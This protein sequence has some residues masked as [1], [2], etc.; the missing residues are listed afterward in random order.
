MRK[1]HLNRFQM[2]A[3]HGKNMGGAFN[4]RGGQWLAAEVADINP[5]HFANLHGV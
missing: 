5:F 3:G 2:R 1:E 4:Q